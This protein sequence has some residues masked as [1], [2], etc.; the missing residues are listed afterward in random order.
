MYDQVQQCTVLEQWA[1]VFHYTKSKH[2][3]FY[4]KHLSHPTADELADVPRTWYAFVVDV[5]GGPRL[6]EKMAAFGRVVAAEARWL[7]MR[8]QIL[9]LR[10]FIFALHSMKLV[11]GVERMILNTLMAL[12]FFCWLHFLAFTGLFALPSPPGSVLSVA[13]N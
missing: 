12:G 2:A 11:L 1:E 5:L 7:R 8:V 9:A 4:Q 6:L 10:L 3:I 13:L